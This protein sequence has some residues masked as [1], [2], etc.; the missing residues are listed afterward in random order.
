MKNQI[1][2]VT[3]FTRKRNAFKLKLC[4]ISKGVAC[5]PRTAAFSILR[6]SH[7]NALNMFDMHL[8]QEPY[9][10]KGSFATTEELLSIQHPTPLHLK[11][12][13]YTTP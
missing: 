12:S 5:T 10:T 6:V 8:L 2:K 13:S 1:F 9:E 3:T 11:F 7:Q 4:S